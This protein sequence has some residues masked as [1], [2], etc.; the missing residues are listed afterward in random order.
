MGEVSRLTSVRFWRRQFQYVL[1]FVLLLFLQILP[2]AWCLGLVGLLSNLAWH[3]LPKERDK[4]LFNLGLVFPERSDRQV[5]GREVFR[6]VGLNAVDA[7][8]LPRLD[9]RRVEELVE[10]SGLEHFD[11]A[12][13]DGRGV[14]A[15]TGHIGCWE[16]IPAWFSQRGY[17]ISV[18]GRKVYDPRLDRL[19][20]SARSRWGVKVIDRD[21]GARE[22]LRSL[23]W[24]QALG[25]LIDQDT[26]VASV[27]AVFMGRPARTPTGAAMLARKTGAAVVPLAVHRL[28]DGRHRI[29]I[30]PEIETS[31]Q[32][33]K[34]KQVLE[35]VQ[36]QTAA[37]E[38]LINLDIRQWAWM[39]LRW[40]EK[41]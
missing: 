33:D 21:E 39:H 2:K 17:R 11:R 23:R 6:Q 32:T 28:P 10:T 34:E 9:G 4:V 35:D 1:I 14:V 29:T 37:I 41:P 36:R 13:R 20:N 15:V 7:I 40:T 31:T 25:I 24:G 18:I 30:L 16:L 38:R 26:R 3:L 27:E 8:R 5:L 19:L 12:Y 22:A